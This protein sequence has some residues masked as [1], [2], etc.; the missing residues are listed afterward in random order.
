M[1]C[2]SHLYGLLFFSIYIQIGI[3]AGFV[4]IVI[5][6]LRQDFNLIIL[7]PEKYSIPLFTPVAQ[8]SESS[9]ELSLL[10]RGLLCQSKEGSVAQETI[11]CW[12][13]DNTSNPII[14]TFK[15]VKKI[16]STRV[17]LGRDMRTLK[18]NSPRTAPPGLLKLDCIKSEWDVSLI[19]MAS[20]SS[21]RCITTD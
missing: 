1:G 9:G 17:P 16:S 21:L 2:E 19:Y 15:D 5:F 7:G 6:E 14:Q 10:E 11:I 13:P 20:F 8:L 4:E 18:E 12:D 3:F